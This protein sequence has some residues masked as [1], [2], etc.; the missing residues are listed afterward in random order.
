[1]DTRPIDTPR[2]SLGA[3]RETLRTEV[4]RPVVR[5]IR[6]RYVLAQLRTVRDTT[7]L[8]FR[9]ETRGGVF[10]P[11]HFL[12]SEILAQRVC[13]LVSPNV[14]LLDM[15][16]GAGPIALLAAA[17]GAQVTACDRNPAAVAITRSNLERYGFD[18]EVLESDLFSA[19]EGRTFD[20]ICFNIPFYEGTPTTH[21]EAAF[22]GGP[23]LETVE[24]FAQG[25]AA[26]LA[27][28]GRVV[29]VFSED[30][31]R[32]RVLSFFRAAGFVLTQEQVSR[33]YFEDFHVAIFA[34]E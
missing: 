16:A 32:A 24:R 22:L 34:R 15:G 12:S 4:A 9:M 14:R 26:H 25:C 31:N 29:I 13:E 18:A 1:M 21:Y 20:L 17:S 7:F 28:K 11:V 19:L 5:A 10:H 27:S 8:G 3:L 6:K 23:A 33:R 2:P 30:T